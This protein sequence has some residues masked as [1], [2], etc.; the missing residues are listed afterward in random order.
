MQYAA[1]A[2]DGQG[3]DRHLFGLKMKLREGEPTPPIYRCGNCNPIEREDYVALE[4]GR[5][6]AFPL[7]TPFL[8]R[9]RNT[10]AV[11][12]EVKPGQALPGGVLMSYPD[13]EID[14]PSRSLYESLTPIRVKSNTVSITLTAMP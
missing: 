8:S 10:F 12:Y 5:A 13:G 1:W 14:E 6:I 3:V 11:Q 4:P 9:G 7:P 2:A